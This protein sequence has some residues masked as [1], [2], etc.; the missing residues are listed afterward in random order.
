MDVRRHV[1]GQ[2]YWSDLTQNQTILGMALKAKWVCLNELMKQ[3]EREGGSGDARM[4]WERLCVLK[5]MDVTRSDDGWVMVKR[6]DNWSSFCEKYGTPTTQHSVNVTE[7]QAEIADALAEFDF[8]LSDEDVERGK[9]AREQLKIQKANQK[10]AR[11]RG[12]KK[13]L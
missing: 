2:P 11:M 12:A 7:F 4:K 8:D 10:I 13:P 6:G 1:L 3:A 5:I 9:I